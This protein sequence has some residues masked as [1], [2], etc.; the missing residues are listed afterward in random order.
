M[1]RARRL[2]SFF[3]SLLTAA[4]I[5]QPAKTAAE[6]NYKDYDI[7][8]F[9]LSDKELTELEFSDADIS[10]FLPSSWEEDE[11]YDCYYPGEEAELVSFYYFESDD[12]KKYE[13]KQDID[14]IVKYF[15]KEEPKENNCSLSAIT[16][17][18]YKVGE[19]FIAKTTATVSGTDDDGKKVR[20]K[21]I[22]YIIPV[23]KKYIMN[24]Y[25]MLDA[26]KKQSYQKDEEAVILTIVDQNKKLFDKYIRSHSTQTQTAAIT[27]KK[28]NTGNTTVTATPTPTPNPT[29]TPTPTPTPKPT[30]V[31][32]QTAAPVRSNAND[33]CG[34]I[35]DSS[36]PDGGYC[37]YHPEWYGLAAASVPTKSYSEAYYEEPSGGTSNFQTWDEP[38][39]GGASYVGNAKTHKFHYSWCSSVSTMNPSNRVEFYSRDEAISYGY[40]SCQRCNP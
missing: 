9:T 23:N 16:T 30:H 17:N 13:P 26:G 4:S 37:S 6:N 34:W 14:D 35:N 22:N 24:I 5:F 18:Y 33:D 25:I 7:E 12:P 19:Q 8:P 39:A 31:P 2:T 20:W 32:T 3:A 27:T 28:T 1:N 21:E 36:F 15:L 29:P 11:E 38:Y 40:I 10:F